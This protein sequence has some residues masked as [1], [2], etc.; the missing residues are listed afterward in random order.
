MSSCKN[1]GRS[2]C[3]IIVLVLAGC[4]GAPQQATSNDT[5][6]LDFAPVALSVADLTVD[7]A[8]LSLTDITVVGDTASATGTD[9]STITVDVKTGA[10]VGAALM[11]LPPGVYSRVQLDVQNLTMT[12]SWRA[13]PVS[14]TVGAFGGGMVSLRSATGQDVGTSSDSSFAI[15]VDPN[16]WFANDILDTATVTD[17]AIVCNTM[18]NPDLAGMLI[19]RIASSFSIR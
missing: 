3:S 13:M 14:I 16:Q 6:T 17:G 12:G 19:G 9:D 1:L 7:S 18:M 4:G 15:S 5:L 8:V 10:T 2:F 11:M